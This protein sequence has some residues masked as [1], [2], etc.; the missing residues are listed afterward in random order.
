MFPL[1]IR[2]R[3]WLTMVVGLAVAL[4]AIEQSGHSLLSKG[5]AGSV[6]PTPISLQSPF[7]QQCHASNSR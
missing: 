4:F 7:W 2:D 6:L 1:V 5:N 3:L